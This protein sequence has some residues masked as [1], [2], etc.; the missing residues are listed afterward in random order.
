MTASISAL[1]HA[2]DRDNLSKAD[3]L[4]IYKLAA[5]LGIDSSIHATVYDWWADLDAAIFNGSLNPCLIVIGVTEHSSCLG[6]CSLVGQQQ[7]ITLH[8]ALIYPAPPSRS[9][10]KDPSHRWNMPLRWMGQQILK[11]VLL[12]EMQHQA[13]ALITDPAEVAAIRKDCHHCRSW[14]DLCN[15][16]AHHLGIGSTWFPIYKRGKTTI[17]KPDGTKDRKN[18]WKVANP[19][20]QPPGTRIAEFV[21]LGCFPHATF[22]ALGLAAKRYS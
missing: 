17:T 5:G 22:T 2:A 18:Q 15:A 13:Q 4:A 20:E 1:S 21:E 16:S 8:Q 6:L 11:D 9:Y 7:R 10:A 19:E 14:A 3:R 12:H